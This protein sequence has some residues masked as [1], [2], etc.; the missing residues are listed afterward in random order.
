MSKI[1]LNQ[2]F[3]AEIGLKKTGNN[4]KATEICN[5][6]FNLMPD[7]VPSINLPTSKLPKKNCK[8]LKK[9][10]RENI[11]LS[12]KNISK[13]WK[14]SNNTPPA[15]FFYPGEIPVLYVLLPHL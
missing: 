7:H 13:K 11:I 3:N 9:K 1:Y 5:Q 15:S 8:V 12:L 10:G 2:L 4:K 14:I 6:I